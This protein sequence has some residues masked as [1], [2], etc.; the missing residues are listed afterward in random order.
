M[1]VYIVINVIHEQ[2]KNCYYI[3]LLCDTL[4]Y[5]HQLPYLGVSNDLALLLGNNT[6]VRF[7]K[8]PELRRMKCLICIRNV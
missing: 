7:S 3:N 2:Q 4:L 8:K 5:S 1:R 6:Q